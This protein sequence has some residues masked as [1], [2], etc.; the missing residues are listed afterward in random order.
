[1]ELEMGE[2][3]KNPFVLQKE[4]GRRDVT[5]P[6]LDSLCSHINDKVSNIKALL[7]LRKI[8]QEASLKAVLSKILHEM[9]LFNDLLNQMELECHHQERK[10]SQLKV[11][12][13]P[14][15][16]YSEASP[17]ASNR[18]YSQELQE[19]IERDYKEAEHLEANMPFHLPNAGLASAAAG[20]PAEKEAQG[21][22]AEPGR[23]KKPGKEVKPVKEIPFL[24]V[25]EFDSVPAYMRGRLTYSQVNAVIQEINKAVASKYKIVRQSTKSMSSVVRNLYIR[26]QEQETKDTKG[27]FF[28]VEADIEEFTQLKA[29]KRFHS[30]LTILRHCQR[31]RE[32]RGSRLVR[33]AVC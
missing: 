4:K 31:V 17:I 1:M 2:E 24:T 16:V 25:E 15:R 23:P 19:L 14:R 12:H 6:D 3:E 29:D 32:I 10:Q 9:F 26:F 8:G 18:A 11:N 27:E 33:Y 22:A 13:D 5:S 30:I 28:I 20:L 21:K 7:Q